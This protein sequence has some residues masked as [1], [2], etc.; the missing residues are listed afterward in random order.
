MINLGQ[1]RAIDNLNKYLK[2]HNLPVRMHEAGICNGLVSVYAKY[3]LEGRREKFEQMLRR[4]AQMPQDAEL[5]SEVNHFATEIVL[6]FSPQLFDK[7]SNQYKSIE[8]LQID[9][10]G[11]KSSFDLGLVTSDQNWGEIVKGLALRGDEALIVRSDDHT[12]TMT[13]NNEGYVVYDPNYKSGFKAFSTEQQL[14]SELHRNVFKFRRGQLGM[15]FHVIRHPSNDTPREFPDV[16]ALYKKYLMPNQAVKDFGK[17]VDSLHFAINLDSSE[18]I[19][20]LFKNGFKDKEPLK[21]AIKAIVHNSTKSLSN[22]LLRMPGNDKRELMQLFVSALFIGRK[23]S[24]DELLKNDKCATYLNEHLLLKKNSQ[25]IIK[26]PWYGVNAIDM[27]IRGGSVACVKLLLEQ[28]DKA[29]MKPSGEQLL[30]Y[31]HQSIKQNKPHLVEIFIDKIQKTISQDDQKYLFQSINM[32]LNAVERTD[33]SILRMLKTVG[34]Q[35]SRNA[36]SMI[37]NKE[38]RPNGY[39]LSIGIMLYRFTDFIKECLPRHDEARDS[40]EKFHEFKSKATQSRES[41]EK[42]TIRVLKLNI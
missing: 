33:L 40:I 6:S 36:E 26:I 21:S 19:D 12:I 25:N 1:D 11:L 9:G 35:F 39:L 5:D 8:A 42:D 38:Q 34:V 41:S 7:K 2:W 3:V 13:K 17:K 20:E 16:N 31:L 27:S 18:A 4:I 24:F 30:T 15:S 10:K 14:I 32:N 28:L 22:L 29:D 23:E 37:N